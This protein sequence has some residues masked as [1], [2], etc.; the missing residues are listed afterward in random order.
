VRGIADGVPVAFLGA[1]NPA[2]LRR[3][4][5]SDP[6][7]AE[8]HIQN[9]VFDHPSV[10]PIEELDPT[11][12]PAIQ[13]GRETATLVG[14]IDALFVSPDGG[15]TIVEA[16]LWHNPQ[17]RREV[18]D[19]IIDYATELSSWPYEQLTRYASGRPASRCGPGSR[20]TPTTPRGRQPSSMRPPA[21]SATGASCSSW[22]GTASARKWNAWCRTY[23]PRL[24]CSSISLS[25]SCGSTTPTST[26]SARWSRRWWRT[27]LP[28]GHAV[29]ARRRGLG[30]PTETIGH[31]SRPS[32][33]LRAG[34]FVATAAH[35]AQWR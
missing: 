34:R 6:S 19:Q 32:P 35:N 5:P 23:R 15:V 16:E 33:W 20:H 14:A 4:S 8:D 25:S 31:R 27:P 22:L 9:V 30:L 11:F 1:K 3:L 12:A 24:A 13:I 10:L 7:L 21:T 2:E 17:A 28:D 29:P 26:T 18:V